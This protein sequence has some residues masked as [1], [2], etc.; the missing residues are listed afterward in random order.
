MKNKQQLQDEVTHWLSL[1]R[2]GEDLKANSFFISWLKEDEN[3]KIAFEEEKEFLVELISLPES[4]SKDFKEDIKVSKEIEHKRKNFL[5]SVASLGSAACILF[6]VYFSFFT[7]NVRFSKNYIASNKILKD[8]TLPD[9]SIVTLDANT[10]L[11]VEFYDNKREVFLSKGKAF[12]SI[13]SNKEKPFYVRTD[14][15]DVKVLGTQF[16]VVNNKDFKVNVK[17]GKVRVSNKNDKLLALLTKEQSLSLDNNFHINSIKNSSSND[18]ALWSKG[19]FNF[20]EVSLKDVIKEFLKYED[21][22]IT[23]DDDSLGNLLITGKFSSKEFDKL[24]SSLPLIHPV[25]VINKQDSIVIIR[26]K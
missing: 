11:K 6:V 17:E 13:S 7:T 16:E 12:F 8:I 9:N 4:F 23:I 18:M 14:N 15:I 24:L 2:E 22:K 26:N 19:E 5:L 10:S 21:I 1:E 25:E 20:K 3:N